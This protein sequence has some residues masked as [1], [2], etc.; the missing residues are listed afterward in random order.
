MLLCRALSLNGTSGCEKV[1]VESLRRPNE[2]TFNLGPP[3]A[4]ILPVAHFAFQLPRILMCR[5][6]SK[7]L[8]LSHQTWMLECCSEIFALS[9]SKLKL[10]DSF[11]RFLKVHFR[12][13]R[14]FE[15]GSFTVLQPTAKCRSRSGDSWRC[16]RSRRL[17]PGQPRDSRFH[18][19]GSLHQV[20][21][22]NFQNFDV[23]FCQIRI[24]AQIV[25]SEAGYYVT[26]YCEKLRIFNS[27][28][29]LVCEVKIFLHY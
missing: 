19:L 27:V 10:K 29:L 24:V 9:L 18:G 12:H 1:V 20:S 28:R 7:I 22:L 3:C 23:V 16:L 6:C 17:G 14:F 25:E 5:S 11:K 8:S 26:W 13:F 4:D 2:R 15:E 21:S